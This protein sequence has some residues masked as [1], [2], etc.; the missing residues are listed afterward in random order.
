M[1]QPQT[2]LRFLRLLH[3]LGN[4][5]HRPHGR[6]GPGHLPA[7]PNRKGGYAT[8][9]RQSEPMRETFSPLAQRRDGCATTEPSHRDQRRDEDGGLGPCV[10]QAISGGNG[11]I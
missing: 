7:R 11:A 1:R 9:E 6:H 4:G 2:F 5:P 3:G 10:E 8:S